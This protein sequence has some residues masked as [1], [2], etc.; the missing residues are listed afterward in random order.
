MKSL[1]GDSDWRE[2]SLPFQLSDDPTAPKPN[3][4]IVNAVLPGAGEIVLS[5]LVLIEADNVTAAMTPGA[6][7]SDRS[8]G[9]V[10][11]IGGGLIGLCGAVIGVL[12]GMGIGRRLIVP[13]LIAG[14][15]LGA[16]LLVTGLVALSIGQ[17][18]GVYYPL[19]LCGGLCAVMGAVGAM[20]VRQRY[21]AV[22][23]RRMEALD[24]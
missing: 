14:S 16:V 18:Y 4:L 23:L 12:A 10:G 11:G 15:A 1:S 5:D 6:W 13:L 24:A 19:L 21:A 3:K 7:W 8:A 22:E 9:L 2:I 17:P 20:T